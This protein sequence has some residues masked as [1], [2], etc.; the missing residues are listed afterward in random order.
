MFL[1]R[2]KGG[3]VVSGGVVRL[4]YSQA[5]ILSNFYKVKFYNKLF[6]KVLVLCNYIA[7]RSSMMIWSW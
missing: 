1:C 5:L 4:F 6:I 3:D 7:S 2:Y